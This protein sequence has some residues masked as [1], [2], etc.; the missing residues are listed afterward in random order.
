MIRSLVLLLALATPA[1]A[2]TAL[3]PPALKASVTVSSDVVRIGDLV[4]N[5]GAVSDVP[6]FRAPDIGT[7]GAVA[8]PLVLEAIRSHD[9]IGI[10][11]RGL[12]EVLVTRAGRAIAVPEI[13][14]QVAQALAGQNGF[15]DARNLSVRFD[16]DVRPLQVE[17][18]ARGDLRPLRV[19]YDPRTTRFDVTFDLDGSP[20]MHRQPLRVTGSVFETFEAVVVTRPMEHGEVFKDSD[21]AMERRPKTEMTGNVVTSR[22]AAIGQAARRAVRPGQPL[23]DADM[24]KPEIVQR[25]DPVTIVYEAPGMVLTI[26][27]TAQETG[28]LGDTIS[29][30]NV[31]SKR[32]V[33]GKISAPGRITVTAVTARFVDNAPAAHG[34]E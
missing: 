23:R 9:L 2:Q 22:D 29:V 14:A 16:R 21:L 31:Q 11:T 10:D 33:Q 24:M 6:V 19:Y 4:E 28:A 18:N 26:R 27:G 3:P 12:S 13:A 5:A 30:L 34:V 8:T 1:A 32:V 7:T 15:G 17:P 25:N 20:S